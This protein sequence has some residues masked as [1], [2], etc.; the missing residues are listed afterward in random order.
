MMSLTGLTEGSL[1]QMSREILFKAL[2]CR[3]TFSLKLSYMALF[4][5]S[6]PESGGLPTSPEASAGD[7]NKC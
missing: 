6:F 3:Q 2:P 4:Y 7:V 5:L 1:F